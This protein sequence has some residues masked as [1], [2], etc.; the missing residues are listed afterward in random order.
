M[1]NINLLPIFK[2]SVYF[3]RIAAMFCFILLCL[4]FSPAHLSAATKP[5]HLQHLGRR[6]TVFMSETP[7]QGLVL[8]LHGLSQDPPTSELQRIEALRQFFSPRGWTIIFPEAQLGC[9]YVKQNGRNTYAWNLTRPAIDLLILE[10]LFRR[11]DREG[12]ITRQPLLCIGYSNGAYFLSSTL[13][14]ELFSSAKGIGMVVGGSGNGPEQAWEHMPV[15][16]VE[17]A[18]G[19]APNREPTLGFIKALRQKK[20]AFRF[21][22]VEGEHYYQKSRFLDFLTWFTTGLLP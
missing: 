9:R 21:R 11:L 1:P 19:D 16:A 13:D 20:I 2:Q 6:V 22:Q 8:Y 3:D 15:L 4:T 14:S 5:I 10:S 17:V 12:L 7:T 18:K